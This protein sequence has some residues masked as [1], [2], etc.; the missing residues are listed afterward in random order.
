MRGGKT[1]LKRI[2]LILTLFLA[3]FISCAAP[4]ESASRISDT[5]KSLDSA[6]YTVV[7]TSSFPTKEL[8]HTLEYAY[9]KEGDSLITVLSPPE[10]EGISL[11][12]NGD[13]SKLSFQDTA[14][15]TGELDKNG[16]SPFSALPALISSWQE[17]NF[18]ETDNAKMFNSDAYLVISQKS[19]EAS[20][21]EYRTWFS[22]DKLLPLYS[23]IFSDGNR[24]IQCKF[25][26]AEHNKK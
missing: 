2:S 24:V 15:E 26:R 3:L 19:N 16:L 25:E 6:E 5:Y 13:D 21:V 1:Y 9:K 7:L 22:K 8:S 20:V 14:L 10:A 17:G 4:A 11:K 18:M 12:I 23:E